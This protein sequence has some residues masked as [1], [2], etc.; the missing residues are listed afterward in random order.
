MEAASD[1]CIVEPPTMAELEPLEPEPDQDLEPAYGWLPRDASTDEV[2]RQSERP[3]PSSLH[4]HRWR[5]WDARAARPGPW[6][7]PRRERPDGRKDVP[8]EKGAKVGDLCYIP[9]GVLPPDGALVVV[10]EGEKAAD[11]VVQAGYYAI[12]TVCGAGS[13]PGPAVVE[14]LSRYAVALSPDND[15]EGRKHMWRLASALEHAGVGS[16]RWVDPPA[17][18]REHWD[19]A[20]VDAETR[21]RMIDDARELMGFGGVAHAADIHSGTS[22]GTAAGMKFR[23]ARDLF[24]AVPELTS[25]TVEPFVADGSIT[26][27]HG[28]A[29][30]AGKTTFDAHM[31]R[32]VLDGTPFLGFRTRRRP[33]VLLS[34]Q[35]PASLR[36]SLAPA[37]LVDRDDLYILTWGEAMGRSWAE[38][39]R[40]AVEIAI[41]LGALIVVDTLPQWAGLRGDSEND[42]GAALEAVEPVQR[43][44]A[45]G[46][47]VLLVRHDRKGSGPGEVGESE[48]G[49]SAFGGAVDVIL[50]LRRG[51]PEERPTIRYLSALSRF[52]ETPTELVIEL[53][54]NGY[55]VLGD[56]AGYART[57]GKQKILDAL[58]DRQLRRA[59]LEAETG[60][61]GERLT[62]LLSELVAGGFLAREGRGVKGDPQRFR[63]TVSIH[64]GAPSPYVRGAVPNEIK[65]GGPRQNFPPAGSF[66]AL[67]NASTSGVCSDCGHALVDVPGKHPVCTNAPGHRPRRVAGTSVGDELASIFGDPESLS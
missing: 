7:G 37:G 29:K 41:E 5:S 11:A 38:V 27:Q 9:G 13:D 16:G 32:S 22:A 43:A 15:D 20:D 66:D 42:S 56:Q 57:E 14:L 64:S 54:P 26:D 6:H 40:Q 30:W 53:T 21:V 19:L 44:A 50:H 12:A 18:A 63:R 10:T 48:R 61:S 60:I 62:D 1:L 55:V 8:W 67:V 28:R 24:A 59:D 17:N 47:P 31:I 46:L 25:W 36:A 51:G 23:T 39:A 33:V 49:S 45:A 52:P 4:G 58:S 35:P 34:E 65:A 2:P 3:G